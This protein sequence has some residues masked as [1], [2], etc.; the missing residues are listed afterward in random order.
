MSA[1]RMSLD[2]ARSICEALAV[3]ISTQTTASADR[4]APS[5]AVEAIRVLVKATEPPTRCS[6]ALA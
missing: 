2:R 4:S 1:E 5:E 3:M 6:C